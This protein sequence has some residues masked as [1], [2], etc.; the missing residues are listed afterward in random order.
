[1]ERFVKQKRKTSY[2]YVGIGFAALA[3]IML[4][5]SLHS[6]AHGEAER[7]VLITGFGA[8]IMW[9][10][11]AFACM[12]AYYKFNRLELSLFEERSDSPDDKQ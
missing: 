7:S 4:I 12:R 9:G 2:L 5:S 1:M 10:I 8:G 6:L 3:L 11:A